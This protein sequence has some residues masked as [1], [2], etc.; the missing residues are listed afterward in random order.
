MN[1]WPKSRRLP[2]NT[3]PLTED[4]ALS[5]TLRLL[6]TRP[7]TCFEVA[8]RLAER[9]LPGFQIDSVLQQLTKLQLL[10]DAR[11]ARDWVRWRDRFH[12][13][14]TYLLQHELAEKGVET[15]VIEAVLA[16]RETAA[17]REDIGI[18][19]DA[20]SVDEALASQLV[21]RRAER[22]ADLAVDKRQS[23]LTNLLLRRGFS[24]SIV[25]KIV[26]ASLKKNDR[27]APTE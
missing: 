9:G 17:W 14:G 6:K 2:S 11:F 27:P 16:E 18:D 26:R 19:G 4:R 5:Y 25:Y 20:A 22:M 1:Q 21:E 24:P 13:S 8:T 15:A 23:R 7:R 3:A 10:D 12:L